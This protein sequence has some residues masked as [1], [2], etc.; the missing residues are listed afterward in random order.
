MKVEHHERLDDKN[1]QI[2]K[3]EDRNFERALVHVKF[4]RSHF[5]MRSTRNSHDDPL[6][7]LLFKYHVQFFFNFFPD[8][9]LKEY[10]VKYIIRSLT[11]LHYNYTFLFCL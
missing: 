7:I 3:E 6:T 2:K 5:F 4:I 1:D 9:E 8:N 10:D 11:L